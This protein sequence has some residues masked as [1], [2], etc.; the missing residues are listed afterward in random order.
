MSMWDERYAA[1]DYAYGVEPNDFLRSV[2]GAH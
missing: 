2:A 1:P